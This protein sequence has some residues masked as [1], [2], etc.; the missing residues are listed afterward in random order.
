MCEFVTY[1]SQAAAATMPSVDADPTDAVPFYLSR[2]VTREKR[3]SA[4][5]YLPS[6]LDQLSKPAYIMLDCHRDEKTL[7]ENNVEQH[8]DTP[9]TFCLHMTNNVVTKR[10]QFETKVDNHHQ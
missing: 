2:L 5:G 9:L 1:R 8:F 4:G 7:L 6:A 3:G 10:C